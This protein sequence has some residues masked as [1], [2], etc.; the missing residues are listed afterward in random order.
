MKSAAMFTDDEW[1][2]DERA[3]I[4]RARELSPVVGARAAE[5]EKLRRIPDATHREFR[6]A[7]FYRVMQPAR[8]GGMQ[9]RYG[10]H[11][12]LAME[13]S[14]GCA[15]SGW[16][17]CVTACHAWILGMFP[18]QAQDEIWGKNPQAA[19]ASTFFAVAPKVAAVDGGVRLS[20][21]WRFS[22]NI[23]HCEAVVVIAMAP[24]A[25]GKPSQYFIVLHPDQYRIED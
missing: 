9:A 5:A 22:S 3:L 11:T 25:D 21:R 10:L 6:D 14:R 7:G 20:G 12:A 15:S 13:I 18:Q 8:Y 4:E 17:L 16:A 24:N 19:I 23:D 1:S 2:H